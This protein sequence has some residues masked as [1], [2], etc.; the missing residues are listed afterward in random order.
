MSLQDAVDAALAVFRQRPS[1]LLPAYLLAPAVAVVARAAALP[2]IALASLYLAATGRLAR[3]RAE[4]AAADLDAVPPEAGPEATTEWAEGIA[5]LAELLLPPTVVG[6]LLVSTVVT[7]A[8][9]VL[10]YAGVLAAQLSACHARLRTGRGLTAAVAGARRYWRPVLGVRLLE[11]A[12]WVALTAAAVGVAGLG[13]AA[14]PVTGALT[15]V[16][17]FLGWLVVGVAVRAVFAFAP[18]AVVVADAGVVGSVTE[19]ARFVRA[20]PVDAAGYYALAVGALVGLST[21]GAALAALGGTPLVGVL[22]FVLVPPALDLVKTALYADRVG[23]LDPPAVPDRSLGA[24]AAGGLRRGWR[25]LG[26]FVRETP[27]LHALAL[28]VLAAGFAAGWAAAAPFE[29]VVTTSIAARL[30]GHVPPAAAVEFG[31]N[32]W[33]VAVTAAYGGV[34]VGLPAAVSL[35]FNGLVLG[36]T[37]RLE[38]APL[39]LLAFV[40]PHGIVEIPA[41]VVSGALGLY[42]G[43]LAWRTLRGRAARGV[44]ADGIERGF[45]VLVGVGLLLGVAGVVEGFVSPFYYR[46]F[47]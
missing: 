18:V 47:L 36:A 22:A 20:N 28:G 46:P 26:A 5:P 2:G 23:T 21:L 3:F 10:A 19:S 33:T 25:E 8:A 34:V 4:L 13:F 24:Q 31:A 15:A 6:I 43:V 27:G 11:A 42:L 1:D 14:S 45:W 44:L 7:A 30:E 39:E 35:V 16:V 41:I 32:N 29:G 9:F 40:L 37:A 17:A 38:V 12:L